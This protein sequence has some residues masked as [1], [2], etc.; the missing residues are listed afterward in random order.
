MNTNIVMWNISHVSKNF[1]KKPVHMRYQQIKLKKNL[2]HRNFFFIGQLRANV[3]LH[4]WA[5]TQ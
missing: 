5:V 3:Y 1:L 2:V 4:I